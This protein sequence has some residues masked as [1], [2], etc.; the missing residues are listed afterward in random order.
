MNLSTAQLF[1]TH[2]KVRPLILNSPFQLLQLRNFLWTLN[3][4]RRSYHTRTETETE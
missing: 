3:I 4:Q 2:L 1:E